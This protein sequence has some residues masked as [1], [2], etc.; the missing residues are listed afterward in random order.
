[1]KCN[2]R[3]GA[4]AG[5]RRSDNL[6]TVETHGYIAHVVDHR[7]DAQIKCPDPKKKARCREVE[8][9]HPGHDEAKRLSCRRRGCEIGAAEGTGLALAHVGRGQ[10]CTPG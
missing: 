7:M 5:Y 6:H 4:D 9:C 1:L 3:L 2:K 10:Q 8:V